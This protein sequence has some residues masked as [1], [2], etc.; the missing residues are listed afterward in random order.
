MKYGIMFLAI[1]FYG[2]S[3]AQERRSFEFETNNIKNVMNLA[4]S[5]L[6]NRLEK[7]SHDDITKIKNSNYQRFIENQKAPLLDLIKKQKFVYVYEKI[8]EQ[9]TCL[10][11]HTKPEAEIILNV[12]ACKGLSFGTAFKLIFHEGIHHLGIKDEYF[13]YGISD[14]I[15]NILKQK[16]FSNVKVHCFD[17]YNGKWFKQELLLIQT[18]NKANMTVVYI[19]KEL[20]GSVVLGI[21]AANVV[22]EER[23]SSSRRPPWKGA[24]MTAFD[25]SETK[26][27][28]SELHG[29][30]HRYKILGNEEDGYF[31]KASLHCFSKRCETLRKSPGF[32]I[33]MYE[34]YFYTFEMACK[35]L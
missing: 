19:D 11:T 31:S 29:T 27:N 10:L 2:L 24:K 15:F 7:I 25:F 23:I 13:A 34:W 35:E 3:Y 28:G 30:I 33:Q 1:M 6:L 17:K 32:P 16:P 9:S 5:E 18:E 8:S 4:R 22:P 21:S 12:P 20:E 26:E 14:E